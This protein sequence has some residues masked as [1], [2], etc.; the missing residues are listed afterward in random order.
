MVFALMMATLIYTDKAIQ[1]AIKAGV[2]TIEHGM[3]I[4]EKKTLQMMKDNDVWLSIYADM[5]LVDGNP[6]ENID[7]IADPHTN[8]VIIMKDGVIYKNTIQ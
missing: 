5:L 2:K 6:L 7:L 1:R 3:L 4:K 8:F